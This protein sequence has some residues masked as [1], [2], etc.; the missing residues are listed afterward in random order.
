MGQ[1]GCR[2]SGG[3]R[4]PNVAERRRAADLA[5]QKLIDHVA[6]DAPFESAIAER[7]AG[8]VMPV[9]AGK[10]HDNLARLDIAEHVPGLALV[11]DTTGA[12][13][14]EP[15]L[16]KN[17]GCATEMGQVVIGPSELTRKCLGRGPRASSHR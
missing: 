1:G 12:F 10:M 13:Q 6:E 7:S 17:L 16:P 14:A 11:R 8:Y 4:R 3:G 5:L 2:A 15:V 9:D